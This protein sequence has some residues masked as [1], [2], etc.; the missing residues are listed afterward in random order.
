[1]SIGWM[2]YMLIFIFYVAVPLRTFSSHARWIVL[3]GNSSLDGSV[4]L[5][6]KLFIM[7]RVL[8]SSN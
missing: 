8:H 7:E 1:M 5:L 2:I 3:N 4:M 6:H